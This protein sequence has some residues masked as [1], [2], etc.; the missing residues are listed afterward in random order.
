[1]PQ[2]VD[3]ADQRLSLSRRDDKKIRLNKLVEISLAE[4]NR[5]V[6]NFAQKAAAF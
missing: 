3:Y 6:R 2:K 1:V 5:T 4:D